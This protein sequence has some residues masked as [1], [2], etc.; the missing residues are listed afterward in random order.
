[1]KSLSRSVFDSQVIKTLQT[2]VQVGRETSLLPPDTTPEILSRGRERQAQLRSG[3]DEGSQP[4]VIYAY[5]DDPPR[6]PFEI[7]VF[8]DAIEID[9]EGVHLQESKRGGGGPRGKITGLSMQSAS[10]LRKAC[11]T[12]TVPNWRAYALSFDVHRHMAVEE[13]KECFLRWKRVLKK[14]GV[15][16]IYRHEMQRR[17]VP[18]FHAVVWLD[19]DVNPCGTAWVNRRYE[20]REGFASERGHVITNSAIPGAS[21]L[22]SEWLWSTRESHDEDARRYACHWRPLDDQDRWAVYVALHNSKKGVQAT[23]PGRQ[24]GY[25]GQER[26]QVREHEVRDMTEADTHVL[27]RRLRKWLKASTGREVRTGCPWSRLTWGIGSGVPEQLV[28]GLGASRCC[29]SLTSR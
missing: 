13:Y 1:M 7:R 27:R 11:L 9:R 10:R 12:L 8:R 3:P 25:I 28:R 6:K 24:W 18:H 2:P 19:P 4:L 5:D 22:A 20:I 14:A 23:Y 26:L 17:G 21:S 16:G 29:T 15:S